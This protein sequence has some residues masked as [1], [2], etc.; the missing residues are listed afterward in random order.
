MQSENRKK[1]K[2]PKDS[3]TLCRI[4]NN[5]D[6]E[7][8]FLYRETRCKGFVTPYT[9]MIRSITLTVCLNHDKNG[10]H[11]EIKQRSLKNDRILF[12]PMKIPIKC[13]KIL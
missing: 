1:K 3:A 5:L 12:A 9:C 13:L 7:A 10:K 8:L 4:R 11:I 6:V 2:N